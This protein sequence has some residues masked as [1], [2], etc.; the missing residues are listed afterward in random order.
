MTGFKNALVDTRKYD[1]SK[2]SHPDPNMPHHS[3]RWAY[4]GSSGSGKTNCLINT[5]E[6]LYF[7]KLYVICPTATTQSKY[8]YLK[9]KY[10]KLDAGLRQ[11]LAKLN[12]KH[13]TNY[14]IED[15][16]DLCETLDEGF[17]ESLNK[18]RV[19]L[20]IFD[21]MLICDKKTEKRIIDCFV[22][23]RHFSSSFI[24]ASQAFFRIPRVIRM[25]CNA[26]NIFH[27]VN[28]S[29]LSMLHKEM[30][31][32]TDKKKFVKTIS[33]LIEPNYSFIHVNTDSL[34]PFREQDMSTAINFN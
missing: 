26:F 24:Y 3:Y 14:D 15:R 16:V 5:I 9:D 10:D 11:Q 6:G 8:L 4:I 30:G 27:S 25:N 28:H 13:K 17:L 12:K 29:E 23:G 22:K 2:V 34:V 21:D 1:G 18:D 20:V 33:K 7:D 32:Q 31:L 19:N